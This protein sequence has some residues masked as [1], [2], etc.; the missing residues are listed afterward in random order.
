[1]C[2]ARAFYRRF[3]VGATEKER[4]GKGKEWKGNEKGT[5]KI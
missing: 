1:M 4:K 5:R 2:V 3:S